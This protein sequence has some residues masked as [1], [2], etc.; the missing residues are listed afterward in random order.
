M[1]D[2]IEIAYEWNEELRSLYLDMWREFIYAITQNDTET[3]N[4]CLWKLEAKM[5][6]VIH[7]NQSWNPEWLF[8]DKFV[9]ILSLSL[10]PTRFDIKKEVWTDRGDAD[11]VIEIPSLQS[12]IIIEAKGSEWLDK[13]LKQIETKYLPVYRNN[14]QR[15]KHIYM[16]GIKRD[17]WN[18]DSKNESKLSWTDVVYI[19]NAKI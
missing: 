16:M 15:F 10:S 8:K 1:I 2:F 11:I 14:K 18:K 6:T 17:K 13:A 7:K 4:Y 19:D 5:K 9:D 12:V 3:I